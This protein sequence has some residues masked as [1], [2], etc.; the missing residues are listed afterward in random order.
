MSHEIYT[1]IERT[2]QSGRECEFKGNY[3][4]A[5]S[6]Y[7][8]AYGYSKDIHYLG[9]METAYRN[10]EYLQPRLSPSTRESF[11]SIDYARDV[12]AA[13]DFSEML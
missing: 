2:M 1:L 4:F 5:Y 13:H 6:R 3:E 8:D 11:D 10:M 9:G 7:N 12:H